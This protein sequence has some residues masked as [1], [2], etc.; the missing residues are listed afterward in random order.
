[1]VFTPEVDL[2]LEK[3]TPAEFVRLDRALA[4]ISLDATIGPEWPTTPGQVALREYSE[5]R[6]RTF[7][8]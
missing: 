3:L 7:I 5:G 4:A 8:T 6:A 2:Y 1:M